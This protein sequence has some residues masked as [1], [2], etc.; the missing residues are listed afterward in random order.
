[1]RKIT[2]K[3]AAGVLAL[4]MAVSTVPESINAFAGENVV[5]EF[6]KAGGEAFL[7]G[8]GAAQTEVT[9]GTYSVAVKLQK[10]GTDMEAEDYFSDAYTSMAGSCI[11][12]PAVLVVHKDGTATATL[13]LT[14]VSM[15]PIT[16]WASEWVIAQDK[17]Y[18]ESKAVRVDEVT[19]EGNPSKISFKIPDISANGVYVSMNTG[20]NHANKAIFA[21]DWKN[22]QKTS[23][24]TSDSSNVEGEDNEVS[25]QDGVYKIS[26]QMLKVDKESLSMSNGAIDHDMK[27]TVKDGK[28]MLTMN[29]KGLTVAGQLGYLDQLKYFQ[30]GYTLDQYGNPQGMLSDVTV[31]TYQKNEDG[32]LVSDSFGTSYPAEITFELIPEAE[33][34]GYVPLQMVVPVMEAIS[35]GTGTQTVFLKLD[36]TSLKE[37]VELPDVPEKPAQPVVTVKTPAV[38]QTVKAVSATYNKVKISWKIVSGATGYEVYQYNSK[39]KKYS[40]VATVK[41]T[42]YTKTGLTTGNS[43]TFKVRAYTTKSGKTAYGS[44]SKA[45]SAKPALSKVTGVKVK[46]SSSK[47]AKVTWKKVSGAS[48][49]EIVRATKSNGKFKKVKTITKGSTVTYTNKKLIKKKKYYYKVRA[50]RKVGKKK[51]Y[52]SYSSKVKVTIKK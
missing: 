27:L 15:G 14:S 19:E 37:W 39:T 12:G 18:T 44:Y 28:K 7:A 22:I 10:S 13:N 31:N 45:V 38:P 33:K 32:T 23:D 26:G 40:K 5:N 2:A 25:L 35:A 36:W 34:D 11:N 49:Y 46:N 21:I 50:Y 51:V 1:M 29:F 30:T 43:Y 20:G 48:G 42:S 9:P 47:A 52:S 24:D 6:G 16:A 17:T 3:I 8:N 41:G 4:M